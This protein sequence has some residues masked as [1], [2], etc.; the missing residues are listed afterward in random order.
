M[1][2][3]RHRVHGRSVGNNGVGRTSFPDPFERQKATL[4]ARRPEGAEGP[5]GRDIHVW[6]TAKKITL[7]RIR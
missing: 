5:P 4:V 3:F 7:C 1:C 2:V 6:A